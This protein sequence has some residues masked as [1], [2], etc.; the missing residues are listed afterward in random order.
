MF[1]SNQSGPSKNNIILLVEICPS[2]KN[3]EKPKIQKNEMNM[4][5]GDLGT[6]Y[7]RFT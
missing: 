3:K 7:T 4:S 1:A 6:S 2:Q 5:F